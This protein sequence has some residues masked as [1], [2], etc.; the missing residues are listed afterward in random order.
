METPSVAGP[1][2]V[3]ALIMIVLASIAVS[4]AAKKLKA[5]LQVLAGMAGGIAAGIVIGAASGN[6][7]LAGHLAFLLMWCGGIWVSVRKIRR[8]RSARKLS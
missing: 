7:V 4:Q 5:G 1:G 8:A 3:L 6:G 2:V